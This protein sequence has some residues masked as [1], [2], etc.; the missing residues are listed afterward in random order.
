M[1]DIAGC[2]AILPG[3]AAE[4]AG[5]LRRIRRN[6]D[7]IRVDDYVARPKNTGYRALHI[8]VRRDDHLVEIQLRTPAQHEWAEAIER[9]AARTGFP[10]KDGDGPPDC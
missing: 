2:R 10:L 3:G 4:V 5:V 7:V 6:W 1:E 9:W 8:V